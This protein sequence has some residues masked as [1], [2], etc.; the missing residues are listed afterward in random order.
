MPDVGSAV[1]LP[2]PGGSPLKPAHSFVDPTDECYVD[3]VCVLVSLGSY[4]RLL[5]AASSRALFLTRLEAGRQGAGTVGFW[6]CGCCLLPVS[7]RGGETEGRTADWDASLIAWT[8]YTHDLICTI[9]LGW[10]SVNLG[11]TQFLAR[12]SPSYKTANEF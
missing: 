3:I 10:V 12:S 5:G 7:S 11:K 2:P 1:T 9:T 4:N 6:A 8:H